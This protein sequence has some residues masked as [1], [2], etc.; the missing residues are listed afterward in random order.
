MEESS[1]KRRHV[2]LCGALDFDQL[3]FL[4]P[5]RPGI[6]RRLLKGLPVWDLRVDIGASLV[7]R[8]EGHPDAHSSVATVRAGSTLVR[9][10]MGFPYMESWTR[11][12]R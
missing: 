5:S 12:N 2:R 6:V 1:I 8:N 3:Q 9:S 4:L 11:P 10:L 7:N